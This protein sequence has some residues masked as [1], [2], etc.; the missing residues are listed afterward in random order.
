VSGRLHELLAVGAFQPLHRAYRRARPAMRPQIRA[1]DE[2]LRFRQESEGWDED[3]RRAWILTRLREVVRRAWRETPY[4]R[5]QFDRL[6]FDPRADFDFD[7]FAALPTLEREDVQRAGKRLVSE[8]VDPR[9]LRRDATGGS[10]GTPTEVWK[11]PEELGWGESG[12]EYFMRR[13]GLP[14][15]S[16]TGFLWGHNLDPTARAGLRE[17]LQ[18]ALQNQ[19]WFECLRLSPEILRAHHA[20]LEATRPRCLVAYASALASL[21]EELRAA[22]L[23]PSYPTRALVTGGEKLYDHQRALIAEVFGKP[24]HERYGSRDVGLMGFQLEPA[25]S[26]DHVVDWSNVLLEPEEDDP[27]GAAILVTKLHADGMPMIRYRVGDVA[28]F[29]AG[30]APGHPAFAL[31]E[32]VGRAADRI[33]LPSGGWVHGIEFPH[34]M[35]DFPVGD[36]QVVQ[37][38]DY[39]VRVSLVPTPGRSLSAAER[40]TLESLLRANM[41]D[42]DLRLEEV[43]SIPRTRANKWRPVM[44]AVTGPR[45]GATR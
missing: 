28:R 24:V 5:E 35:K 7:D 13:I 14:P 27:G 45:P 41:P 34:M 22:G 29:P 30:S 2:G 37:A 19:E 42:V 9:L 26:L 18:D 20:R 10:T 43:A 36:F 12:S 17:R 39:S 25:S 44:T 11:G 1:R 40:A 4:Y 6:G 21:A 32:V 38:D 3:R 33:W 16:A 8:G 31:H 15:G 23:R